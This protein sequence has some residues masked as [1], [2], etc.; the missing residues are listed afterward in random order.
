MLGAHHAH[1]ADLGFGDLQEHDAVGHLLLGQ[2]D[3]HGLVAAFLVDRLQGLARRLD[4]G[5]QMCIRDR[6]SS[7]AAMPG[8]MALMFTSPA[9]AV[10]RNTN[11]I[12]PGMAAA[13]LATAMGL[14]V[15]IPALFGYNLSLIHISPIPR[16][17]GSSWRRWR[18]C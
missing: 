14:F 7:A 9:M 11:A 12:A 3:V 8:A 4:V 16:A 17:A 5:Q 6:A 2:V 18:W 10:P 13:L 1:A 15:A